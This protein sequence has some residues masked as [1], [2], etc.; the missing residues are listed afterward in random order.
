LVLGAWRR[1]NRSLATLLTMKALAALSS[2]DNCGLL[3]GSM[4]LG[5]VTDAIYALLF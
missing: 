5:F 2:F 1:L 3:L 4:M